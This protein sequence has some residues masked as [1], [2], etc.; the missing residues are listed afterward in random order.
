MSYA[1]SFNELDDLL[2]AHVV[3]MRAYFVEDMV[4]DAQATWQRIA[5]KRSL[6]HARGL[7][8]DW[9]LTGPVCTAVVCRVGRAFGHPSWSRSL[10]IAVVERNPATLRISELGVKLAAAGGY[11]LRAFG[12]LDEAL[13]WLRAQEAWPALADQGRQRELAGV[14]SSH[15]IVVCPTE[16]MGDRVH[17]RDDRTAPESVS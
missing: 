9:D 4:A 13:Q 2:L 5:R 17:A 15:S 7:L 16:R 1:V 6:C 8:V 3:G 10:P 12:R 14:T 11:N